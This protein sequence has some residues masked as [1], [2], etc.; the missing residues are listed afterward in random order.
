MHKIK[1]ILF[2]CTTVSATYRIHDTS[3]QAGS[4]KGD[5]IGDIEEPAM[6]FKKCSL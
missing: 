4:P 1:C 3:P 2:D 6:Y 5:I